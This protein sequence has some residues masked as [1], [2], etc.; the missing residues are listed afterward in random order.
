MEIRLSTQKREATRLG[1]ALVIFRR[2]VALGL[3]ALSLVY[4]MQ[5]VG[6]NDS[7]GVRI[8]TMNESWQVASAVLAVVMPIAAMGLW[9][10]FPWGTSMWLLTVAIQLS[11]H[12][13]MPDRFGEARQIVWFHLASLAAYIFIKLLMTINR[14]KRI[15]PRKH[16]GA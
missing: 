1:L 4:W 11:M 12:L 9:G 7:Q 15:L 13:G 3:L 6:Y 5:I 10:L 2:I 14:R 16:E 8:D